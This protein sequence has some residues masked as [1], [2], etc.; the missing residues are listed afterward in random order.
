MGFISPGPVR[1]A[2]SLG[3]CFAVAGGMVYFI[4]QAPRGD[5]A[6]SAV[7]QPA[8]PTP[9]PVAATVATPAPASPVLLVAPVVDVVRVAPDGAA[10]VA[11]RAAPGAMV[12]LFAGKEE[13][14][15]ARADANGDFV[16]LF[17]A[18]PSAAAR[19]LTLDA[20]TPDGQVAVSDQ[21]IVL[22]PKAPVAAPAAGGEGEVKAG[23]V[24]AEP[25]SPL[26]AAA[27][28]S[29]RGVSVTP[30]A[31][32]SG[33]GVD[34]VALASISYAGAGEVALAGFGLPG[35]RIR[36][37]VDDAFAGEGVVDAD[38][39]WRLALGDVVAGLYRL[40]IDQVGPGGKVT[41]R[42]QTPFKREMPSTLDLGAGAAPD[43]SVVVQPGNSLWTLARL[44]YGSGVMYSQIFSANEDLIGDPDLIYPGQIFN[45][46]PKA[47]Q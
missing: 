8:V 11:G 24:E 9:E 23:E 42:V 10:L 15:A 14:A 21:A 36:A 32:P 28:V 29:S 7:T 13:V 43:V 41:S 6:A 26:A 40:R 46:P 31:R 16:A 34:R 39:T 1:T 38:G 25:V 35:A 5:E 37:Y 4:T 44:H 33:A 2:V 20:T 3:V 22:L 19:A 45:L 30:L 47:T 12:T 18:D 17:H 27:V